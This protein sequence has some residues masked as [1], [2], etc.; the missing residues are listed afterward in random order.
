MGDP[1]VEITEE[2]FGKK[3]NL[4]PLDAKVMKPWIPRNTAGGIV[5]KG[6]LNQKPT[7]TRLKRLL[8]PTSRH[9]KREVNTSH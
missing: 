4:L 9:W 2:T 7:E 3:T 1:I 6:V 5:L 8:S